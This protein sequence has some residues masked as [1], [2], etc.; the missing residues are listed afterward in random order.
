MLL[1][2]WLLGVGGRFWVLVW[3]S[4][5]EFGFWVRGVQLLLPRVLDFG[6]RMGLLSVTI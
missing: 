3:W 6:R 5:V 1:A 4:S 2:C